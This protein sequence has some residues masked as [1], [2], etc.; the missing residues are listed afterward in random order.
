MWFTGIVFIVIGINI[1]FALGC[2]FASWL[3]RT[4]AERTLHEV[5]ERVVHDVAMDVARTIKGDEHG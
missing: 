4:K 2:A 3:F 1:G 5:A